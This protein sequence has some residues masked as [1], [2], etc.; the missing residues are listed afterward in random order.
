MRS[1]SVGR[2]PH[3][4][5]DAVGTGGAMGLDQQVHQQQVHQQQPMGELS[6][7]QRAMWYL[8]RT[9]P[10]AEAYNICYVAKATQVLDL[11]VLQ[12]SLAA[13]VSRHRSL[14]QVFDEDT[15]DPSFLAAEDA[16]RFQVRE[17]PPAMHADD[18]AAVRRHVLSS[19]TEC[20]QQRWSLSEGPVVDCS[21]F[22]SGQ[23][24]YVA[25]FV[26][27]IS[28]D[29]VALHTLATEWMTLYHACARGSGDAS[30]ALSIDANAPTYE[31]FIAWQAEQQVALRD[32]ALAF[33]EQELASVPTDRAQLPP[34][35]QTSAEADD[36]DGTGERQGAEDAARS[37]L[38]AAF[39]LEPGDGDAVAAVARRSH[40]TLFALLLSLYQAVLSNAASERELCVLCPTTGRP[41]EFGHVVGHFI[42]TVPV[43][44]RVD[45]NKTLAQHMQGVFAG[46]QQAMKYKHFFFSN[47]VRAMPSLRRKGSSQPISD[48]AINFF[49]TGV[50]RH[51]SAAAA[52]L[53]ALTVPQQTTAFALMLHVVRTGSGAW[54]V[55][56]RARNHNDAARACL[57]RMAWQLETLLRKVA[58]DADTALASKVG[59]LMLHLDVLG[60][61]RF[62]PRLDPQLL[63]LLAREGLRQGACRPSDTAV[64]DEHG[65]LTYAELFWLANRVHAW[66]A[67]KKLPPSTP[68]GLDM[69]K[70]R[71]QPA[72]ALGVLQAGCA[73]VPF[74]K[75]W[76]DERTALVRERCELRVV[77]S[78]QGAGAP[79][80]R[81]LQRL[82]VDVLH[83]EYKRLCLQQ[84]Q[85]ASPTGGHGDATGVS[86]AAVCAAKADGETEQEWCSR[87]MEPH[88]PFAEVSPKDPAYI[89]F[90]SGST[91]TPKGVVVQ[92]GGACN[93]VV[94]TAEMF[95]MR[96]L[97]HAFRMFAITQLT[98][99]LSIFDTFAVPMSGG[100]IVVP[101]DDISRDPEAWVELCHKYSVTTWNSVPAFAQMLCEYCETLEVRVPSMQHF[102][103][104]G[105]FVP[106][107]L[108]QQLRRVTTEQCAVLAL[109]GCTETSIW[110]NYYDVKEVHESWATIPYG[111][112]L[113]GQRVLVLDEDMMPCAIGEEGQLYIA[114][115]SVALG[116][117]KAP[118]LTARAFRAMP[119][120]GLV[121]E[122]GEF[123][124][125]G[126]TAASASTSTR[127]PGD[128]DGDAGEQVGQ[129]GG[130]WPGLQPV[131]A[132]SRR[133]RPL[134]LYATGDRVV[135]LPDGALSLLGRIDFQVKIGGFRVELNE[136]DAHLSRFPGIHASCVVVIEKQLVVYYSTQ[137][138]PTALEQPGQEGRA[139]SG[140]AGARTAKTWSTDA[141]VAFL[142]EK[143]PDY[144][145]PGRYIELEMLP[146]NVNGKIDR[147]TLM[148]PAFAERAAR[149]GHVHDVSTSCGLS[150]NAA[151]VLE[152]W[153]QAFAGGAAVS[154]MQAVLRQTVQQAGGDSLSTVM[155]VSRVRKRG[156]ALSLRKVGPDTTLQQVIDLVDAAASSS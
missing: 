134:R 72:A 109:G 77:L 138:Q 133:D 107:P 53:E 152:V 106:L 114:G 132:R 29:F 119:L 141:L 118:D 71:Y 62:Q 31:D 127:G 102:M 41:P 148:Q 99:D 45:V 51:G 14:C 36:V 19:V 8:W 100:V 55:E 18:A 83:A 97:G 76:P 120:P 149:A 44:T 110:N 60:L 125:V 47:I 68:V 50:L 131:A 1:R 116:Y 82:D 56:L 42:N 156:F 48:V 75:T 112:S 87:I 3:E 103:L 63:H 4:R 111:Y 140:A 25:L 35:L 40:V 54:H 88:V 113:R 94:H 49:D 98:F 96:Q 115:D 124:L 105:D 61:D 142:R 33:Y 15:G 80:L 5:R 147:K 128:D 95:G 101:T 16:L 38:S 122:Q 43:H 130:D 139:V 30:A 23:Q 10:S 57:N 117:Y 28:A 52:A 135:L 39:E 22:C 93:T 81:D 137:P 12:E 27:H 74:S 24:Q 129:P 86:G 153:Q 7:N 9:L 26:H 108:P 32:R 79:A 70:C 143:L 92:H 84:R 46:V 144:M 65:E 121:D 59:H 104:S 151:E 89:L 150:Q 21:V 37:G 17:L 2:L 13:V 90:T 123:V 146:L 126:A 154:D 34:A 91:G 145:V 67:A 85:K 136:I 58:L 78:M 6:L 66:L 11:R 155:F 69:P 64:A 20:L 73:F